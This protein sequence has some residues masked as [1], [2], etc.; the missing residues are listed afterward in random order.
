MISDA[1]DRLSRSLRQSRKRNNSK[2]AGPLER[3]IASTG[4][5]LYELLLVYNGAA[6]VPDR[7][8]SNRQIAVI[9]KGRSSC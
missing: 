2:G 9:K 1:L 5:R 6:S 4:Q 3:T 8:I 7:Q